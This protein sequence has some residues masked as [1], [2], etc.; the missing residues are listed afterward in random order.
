MRPPLEAGGKQGLTYP[1]AGGQAEG[2]GQGGAGRGGAVTPRSR[3]SLPGGLCSAAARRLQTRWIQPRLASQG[4]TESF[5]S[6]K[7]DTFFFFM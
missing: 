1:Q 7:L 2:W 5:P 3:L 4:T 6:S